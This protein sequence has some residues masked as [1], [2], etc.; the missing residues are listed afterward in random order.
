M[1]LGGSEYYYRQEGSNATRN[2]SGGFISNSIVKIST[3]QP[4]MEN[5]R[6]ILVKW[7]STHFEEHCSTHSKSYV[8]NN[9]KWVLGK[10]LP[11]E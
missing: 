3:Q 9:Q 10:K 4:H 6:T 8:K 2:Y 1:Q 11:S 7:V 5:Q